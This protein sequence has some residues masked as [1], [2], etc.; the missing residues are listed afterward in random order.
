MP[1]LTNA[2]TEDI[3]FD[4]VVQDL[5]F[6]ENGFLRRVEGR[7]RVR[8]F[9]YT[10]LKTGQGEWFLDLDHGTPW[11]QEILGSRDL[12]LAKGL[13]ALTLAGVPGVDK[14]EDLEVSLDSVTR[15]LQIFFKVS[16]TVGDEVE[17]EV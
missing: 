15:L 1:N 9:I 8:Q 5:S 16:T 6:D 2:Q 11:R 13:I 10:T 12:E 4:P 17:G 14:V 3:Y 7:E